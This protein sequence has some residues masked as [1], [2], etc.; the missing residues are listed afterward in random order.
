MAV[1]YSALSAEF[2]SARVARS[3]GTRRR[4]PFAHIGLSN[5]RRR[6]QSGWLDLSAGQTLLDVACGAGGPALRIAAA[7]GCSV[8]GVDRH[9]QLAARFEQNLG[10]Y[11]DLVEAAKHY[12]CMKAWVEFLGEPGDSVGRVQAA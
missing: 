5:D 9:Q 7:T 12:P 10:A 11:L 2:G 4:L 8:I 6:V 3:A 1:A